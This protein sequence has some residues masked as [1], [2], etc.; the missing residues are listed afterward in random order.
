MGYETQVTGEIQ[1]EP[2]VSWKYI[3]ESV[4]LE[5]KIHTAKRDSRREL[6]LQVDERE[7]ETDDGTLIWKEGVAL[8]PTWGNYGNAEKMQIHLQEFV[9]AF[10]EHV[11]TGRI[12]GNGEDNDDMWRL[13]VIGRT[14]TIFT[15]KIVWDEESE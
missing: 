5:D 3:R 13:K 15:P 2:P 8:V 11:F 4:F 12:D 14:A 1:I 6:K 7:V 9:D 10:P